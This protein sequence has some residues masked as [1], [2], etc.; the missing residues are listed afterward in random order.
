MLDVAHNPHAA[1]VLAAT[2]GAMGFHPETYAVFGMYADK[3]IG[4]VVDAVKA[5]IDHWYVA[6][7]PGARGAPALTIIEKLRA[8][9]IAQTAIHAFDTITSA[10]RAARDAA[11]NA[12]R[13]I[14]FG[15]FLTVSAAL[16]ASRPVPETLSNI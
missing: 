16:A 5:R 7:L 10:F 9:G 15:S 14:V 1:R 4:G 12:D 6:G 8:A 11:S 13:I 2:L 3:D